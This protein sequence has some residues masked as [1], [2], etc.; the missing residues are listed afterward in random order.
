MASFDD[1]CNSLT[2]MKEDLSHYDTRIVFGTMLTRTGAGAYCKKE[3]QCDQVRR[4]LVN[5]FSDDALEAIKERQNRY[6]FEVKACQEV[7]K[8]ALKMNKIPTTLFC[9]Q[10]PTNW[11]DECMTRTTRKQRLRSSAT[12]DSTF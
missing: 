12:S 2:D 4:G 7:Y 5:Y 1:Q 11:Q 8:T 10:L 6:P 9:A 3:G